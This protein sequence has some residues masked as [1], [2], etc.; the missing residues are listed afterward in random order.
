MARSVKMGGYALIV[1]S[2][3]MLGLLISYYGKVIFII[4]RLL[5][6]KLVTSSYFTG[7]EKKNETTGL[8]VKDI[9]SESEF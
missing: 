8:P 7:P 6:V 4:V 2:I 9:F 3:S 1:W 5:L